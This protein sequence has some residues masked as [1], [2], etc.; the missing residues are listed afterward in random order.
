MNSEDNKTNETGE[1]I[2][3]GHQEAEGEL[4]VDSAA[5]KT[6]KN[7]RSLTAEAFDWVEILVLSL[8]FVLLLFT[9]VGRLAIVDGDSMKETL[10]D[11]EALVIS[12]LGYTAKQNDIVVFQKPDTGG[13]SYAGMLIKPIVKRVIATP[14]QTVYIDFENWAVYVYDDS[15]LTVEQVLATVEPLNE[16]YVT[17]R[18]E[19]SMNTGS[20]TY[21][22]TLG[23]HEL[24]CMGDNRNHSTDSRDSRIGP[25]DERYVLGKVI[26]RILPLNSFGTVN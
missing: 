6:E 8:S 22:Y 11:G 14:G 13:S 10:H 15:S 26:I 21:P 20:Y 3:A 7:K 16:D 4:I 24:F 25:V 18:T 17:L 5:P 19:L 23:E 2:N 9:Y 1:E 12:D